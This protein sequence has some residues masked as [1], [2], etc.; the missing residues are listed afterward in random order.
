MS[1]P[2]VQ[3][4]EFVSL[5]VMLLMIVALVAGQADATA[6]DEGIVRST[7][8]TLVQ[9]RSDIHLASQSLEKALLINVDADLVV[10]DLNQFR[11]EDE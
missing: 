4:S 1:R 3:I 10:N 5:V 2:I 11:G 8:A 6:H 9:D 7:D